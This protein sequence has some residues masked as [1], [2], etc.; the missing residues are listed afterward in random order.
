MRSTHAVMSGLVVAGLLVLA[1]VP[2]DAG[3][4]V[5]PTT[6]EVH[7]EVV[8]PGPSGPYTIDVDCPGADEV[9][10]DPFELAAGESQ[11]VLVTNI[12]ESVTCTVTETV[13]Q[14]ATVTY[15]CTAGFRAGCVDG[16]SIIFGAEASG[17]ITVTNTFPEPEPEPV[18][19][20]EPEPAAAAAGV[21]AARP[22]F[23]G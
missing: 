19:D 23:T 21:V 15:A 1:P 6:L 3:D 20:P 7:K 16:Q 14:G 13:T 5:S 11:E 17:S 18:P 22:A 8:G 12:D 4:L 2:A 9:P 10:D